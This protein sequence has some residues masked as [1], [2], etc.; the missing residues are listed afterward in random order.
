MTS[1]EEDVSESSHVWTQDT[2]TDALSP[3]PTIRD[4][5]IRKFYTRQKLFFKLD[6][7]SIL[8][9]MSKPNAGYGI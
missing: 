2:P 3:Q 1:Q 8:T 6:Q 9:K 4:S 7:M 5:T